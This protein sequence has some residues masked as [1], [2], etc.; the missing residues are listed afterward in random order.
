MEQQSTFTRCACVCACACLCACVLASILLLSKLYSCL[1][2]LFLL[3]SAPIIVHS[4][5]PLSHPPPFPLLPFPPLSSPAAECCKGCFGRPPAHP[6]GDREGREE[7]TAC[8]E[9]SPREQ[10][11]AVG[12][13][14]L[15]CG[16]RKIRQA[17]QGIVHS[18]SI[19]T[20]VSLHE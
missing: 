17:G 11:D 14:S 13:R 12:G 8:A 15:P 4:F 7:C 2:Y 20:S 18:K 9:Q 19:L 5:P 1:H 6:G 3:A 16:T 10:R